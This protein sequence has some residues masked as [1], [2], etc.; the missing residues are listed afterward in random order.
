MV[1]KKLF[2]VLLIAVIIAITFVFTGCAAKI[3][4]TVKNTNEIKPGKMIVVGKISI[5]GLDD[6]DV[7]TMTSK[8]YP[9][10]GEMTSAARLT[11]IKEDLGKTF[12]LQADNHNFY[13]LSSYYMSSCG[14]KCFQVNVV[15]IGLKVNIKPTDKAVYIGNIF[16]K[17]GTKKKAYLVQVNDE[18]K[19]EKS[20]FLKRFGKTIK[21]VKRLA[22]P[23]P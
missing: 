6:Q 2:S 21:L 15:P 14:Y 17:R 20:V 4:S 19:K 1:N 9:K 10:E 7:E 11:N 12:Y 18:F 3:Y 22:V 5:E 23:A 8:E 13:I 16:L